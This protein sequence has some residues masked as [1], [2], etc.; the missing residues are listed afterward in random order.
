MNLNL[1][2][3]K[4][5]GV[6][7]I[8]HWSW[9]LI[10]AIA[11]ISNPSFAVVYVGVFFLVLLHE[12]GHSMAGRYLQFPTKD[13]TL[14]PFGG[15]AN[16]QIPAEPRQEM[17]VALAGPAVN[18]ILFPVFA[19]LQQYDFCR[20]LGY[21]NFALFVF[22]VIPA[23]P[24]DGGRVLR[25]VLSIALRDHYRATLIAARIGQGF[26]VLFVVVG[27]TTGIYMLV[28][29]ALFIWMAA[30]GEIEAAKWKSVED[31]LEAATRETIVSAKGLSDLQ[32]RLARFEKRNRDRR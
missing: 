30:S 16:M 4:W 24:M 29:I 1:S 9:V 6:P 14:Y 10:F 31:T 25:A 23:F 17:F 32:Q 28:V 5:F 3:G 15:V 26:C 20:L 8:L 27:I 7:V 21:Y 2:L 18:V 11:L 19:M 22:N 12:L 13:I